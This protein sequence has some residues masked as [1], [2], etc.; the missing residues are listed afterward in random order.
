M[1]CSEMGLASGEDRAY[2]DGERQ[3]DLI[4]TPRMNGSPSSTW[5]LT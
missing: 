4:E 3:Q 5:Q 2:L 1:F